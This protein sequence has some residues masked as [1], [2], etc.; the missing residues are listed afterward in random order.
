MI[1]K[2][3]CVYVNWI[4]VIG[5]IE[6]FLY[7]WCLLMKDTYDIVVCV[8][9]IPNNQLARLKQIVKVVNTNTKIECETLI[10]LRISDNVPKNITYK[11]KI[12]MVH[13]AKATAHCNIPNADVVVP[14]SKSI[15]DSWGND[16]TGDN[17]KAILNPINESKGKKTLKLISCTRLTKEK[18][19]ERMVKLA[20][21]LKQN[22]IPFIWFVLTNQEIGH[23][24]LF[25]RLNPTLNVDQ[26]VEMCDYLVQLSDTESFC[27]S[28]VEA[29][30]LNVPVITTPTEPLDEIGV[31]DGVN[32]FVVPFNMQGI[33]IKKIYE[34]KLKF[35]YEFDNK[36]IKKQW[37]DLLGES[38]P[39]VPYKEEFMKIKVIKT[40]KDATNNNELVVKGAIYECEKERANFIV[41]QGYAEHIIQETKVEEIPFV[42]TK[43][44]MIEE[45]EK[46]VVEVELNI[47]KKEIAKEVVKKP[48]TTKKTTKKKGDK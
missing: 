16:L 44:E 30:E 19:F 15:I 27:Y 14:V 34:S 35:N 17:V 23:N 10:V 33:D 42:P 38:I 28:I 41:E 40:F 5:G 32:G 46:A 13:G 25:I 31:K 4:N 2:Q 29:L 8:N 47:D 7:N 20:T 39:F 21:L 26:L 36:K 1:K 12:Q 24:D 48:K 37:C 45:E 43:E 18:G 11:N 9:S 3:I 6:T 22:D